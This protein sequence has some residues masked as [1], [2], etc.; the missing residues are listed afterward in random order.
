MVRPM[1][2][3]VW[4][5]ILSDDVLFQTKN[6]FGDDRYYQL[7]VGRPIK[8]GCGYYGPCTNPGTSAICQ[9]LLPSNSWSQ[10]CIAMW[11][12]SS[13]KI[14]PQNAGG[15]V[16]IE[17]PKVTEGN[18][19]TKFIIKCDPKQPKTSFGTL[20]VVDSEP[21]FEI[22]LMTSFGCS[23][24]G[25]SSGTSLGT[26]LLIL[27]FV[28]IIV[29]IISGILFNKFKKGESGMSLVPNLEFWKQLP[30]L[31]KDGALFI[32]SRGKHTPNYD[33]L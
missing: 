21:N 30:G 8:T 27:L 15:G 13:F 25:V 20:S 9:S 7:S 32:W 33:N 5:Q 19:L 3:R 29:Y 31:V 12:P 11:Q 16:I 2:S 10:I 24:T 18:F 4:P 17:F 23:T 28:V 14:L 6:V 1:T 22:T 26:I